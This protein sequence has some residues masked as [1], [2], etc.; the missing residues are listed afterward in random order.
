MEFTKKGNKSGKETITAEGMKRRGE[1]RAMEG[2]YG[3]NI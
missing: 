2:E 1:E 3:Q